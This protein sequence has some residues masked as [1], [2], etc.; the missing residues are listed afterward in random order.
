MAPSEMR[1]FM[2]LLMTTFSIPAMAADAAIKE[3][4]EKV[5]YAYV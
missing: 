3:E 4:V 1:G 2:S 5:I